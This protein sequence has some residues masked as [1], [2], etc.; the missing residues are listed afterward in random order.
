MRLLGFLNWF[1]FYLGFSGISFVDVESS[2]LL[3]IHCQL[4]ALEY[5]RSHSQQK[6]VE[7][8]EKNFLFT[9]PTPRLMPFR[10]LFPC[11]PWSR[12]D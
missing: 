5:M 4:T 10:P 9:L 3:A 8:S 11:V 1:L 2:R 6:F 12:D 7:E